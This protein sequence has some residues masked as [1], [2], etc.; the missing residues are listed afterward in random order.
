MYFRLQQRNVKPK[1]FEL[2]GIGIIMYWK[3]IFDRVKNFLGSL[4]ALIICFLKTN[5]VGYNAKLRCN[6]GGKLKIL[7]S[8]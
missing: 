8:L 7:W 3:L 6:Q 5:R 4:V 1:T 2:E